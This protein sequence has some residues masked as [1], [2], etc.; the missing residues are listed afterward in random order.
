LWQKVTIVGLEAGLHRLRIENRIAHVALDGSTLPRFLQ[1]D[2]RAAGF[3]PV[4]Q[5]HPP[6]LVPH[7]PDRFAR[8][9]YQRRSDVRLAKG[10]ETI[11]GLGA[12]IGVTRV[13]GRGGAV[14]DGGQHEVRRHRR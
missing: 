7:F 8:H 13:Q 9:R 14:V 12:D 11:L 5:M 10:A 2:D 6:F 3:W 1:V 4:A